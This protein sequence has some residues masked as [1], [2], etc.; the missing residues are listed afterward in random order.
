M[1]QE[2][3]SSRRASAIIPAFNEEKTIKEVVRMIEGHPLIEEIIVVN[4]GSTDKTALE[5]QKTSAKVISL[6]SNQGKAEAMARGVKVAKNPVIFFTD[7]DIK[8]LTKEMITNLVRPVLEGKYEMVVALRARKLP[9]GLNQILP[10]LPLLS[11]ARVITKNL[12]KR[13]PQ[14]YKKRFKIEMALN[15]YAK[16]QEKKVGS[17]L[18]S[19]LT[20]VIKEKKWGFWQGFWKR[21]LM[22]GD[23]IIINWQ[24]MILKWQKRLK[25][26]K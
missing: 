8:G 17:I 4:D 16:R 7:A 1:A 24:L 12:W 13:V 3:Y 14:K 10:R 11:G 6:P 19:G 26:K 2:K 5:A 18:F 9:L 25:I 23:L 22:V 20:Q 21:I 15:Y